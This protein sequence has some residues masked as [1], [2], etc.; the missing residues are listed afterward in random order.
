MYVTCALG[1]CG[2]FERTYLLAEQF[3]R[4]PF[5]IFRLRG[6]SKEEIVE[7]LRSFRSAGAGEESERSRS[8]PDSVSLIEDKSRPLE[9]CMD[10][11]WQKGS[12]LD[13]LEINP[14]SPP[15]ENAVLKILGKAPISIGK[16]NLATLLIKAY[17]IAGRAAL[18]KA[19]RGSEEP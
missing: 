3:D 12:L 10:R 13:L 5:L 15:V 14:G 18:Q 17:E 6:K 4:D 11:F 1:S 19:A 2:N 16:V 7:A 8:S 9:E